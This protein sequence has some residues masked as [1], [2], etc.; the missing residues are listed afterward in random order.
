MLLMAW[1]H[2][3]PALSFNPSFARVSKWRERT[4]VR[5]PVP[6]LTTRVTILFSSK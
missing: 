4:P 3:E 5:S 6:L 1:M 2:M